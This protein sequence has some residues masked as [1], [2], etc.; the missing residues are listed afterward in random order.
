MSGRLS[1]LKDAIKAERQ[2]IRPE[3]DIRPAPEPVRAAPKPKAREG[4]HALVGY[5]SEEMTIE[6]NIIA[7]RRKTSVQAIIGEALD[8]WMES[9]NLNRFGER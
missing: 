2:P 8:L 9:N 3:P 7:K 6:V 5:F 4:K 1:G